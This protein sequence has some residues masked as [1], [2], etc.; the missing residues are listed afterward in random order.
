MTWLTA[1][2]PA[3]WQE[4]KSTSVSKHMYTKIVFL[5]VLWQLIHRVINLLFVHFITILI[6][7]CRRKTYSG[8]IMWIEKNVNMTKVCAAMQEQEKIR[9]IVSSKK[10][11]WTLSSAFIILLVIDQRSWTFYIFLNLKKK[12][13]SPGIQFKPVI[14]AFRLSSGRTRC[15]IL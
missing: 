12:K 6:Y 9:I 3:H 15:Y 7:I 8:V 4:K 11:K 5:L 13:K 14:L 2:G 10:N 1:V